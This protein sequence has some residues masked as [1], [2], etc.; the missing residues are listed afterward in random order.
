MSSDS[1]YLIPTLLTG[2]PLAF[3][4]LGFS[5]FASPTLP[6]SVAPALL[7]PATLSNQTSLDFHS[8][9]N[10]PSSIAIPESVRATLASAAT[11]AARPNEAHPFFDVR[12]DMSLP[13]PRPS[14]MLPTAPAAVSSNRGRPQPVQFQSR[15]PGTR[16]ECAR[17]S[18]RFK[19][20]MRFFPTA[21]RPRTTA[22]STSAQRAAPPLPPTSSPT[23]NPLA[24]SHRSISNRNAY[25]SNSSFNVDRVRQGGEGGEAAAQRAAE[26]RTELDDYW[27]AILVGIVRV[28]RLSRRVYVLGGWKNGHAVVRFAFGIFRNHAADP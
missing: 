19:R 26:R 17:A 11:A 21:K 23:P 1:P 15:P 12:V 9:P 18:T 27:D 24:T 10:A 14:V 6:T 4:A 3:P 22:V 8:I 25:T 16:S 2:P 5:L 7:T 20:L 13:V 28:G